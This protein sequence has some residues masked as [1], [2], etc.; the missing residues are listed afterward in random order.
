MTLLL[1]DPLASL[2]YSVDWGSDYLD[3]D[4]LAASSW[5]VEPIEAGGVTVVSSEFG[6]LFAT[7]TVS[8]GVPGRLYRLTNH[9][10]TAGG[11]ED[12][13]SIMLRVEKR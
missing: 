3:A 11:Y 12:S 1:K 10:T 8:G 7:V 2:D 9:V 4:G 5:T 13:R 6:P